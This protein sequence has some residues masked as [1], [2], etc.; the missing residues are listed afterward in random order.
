M[1]KCG[2]AFPELFAKI[3]ARDEIYVSLRDQAGPEFSAATAEQLAIEETALAGDPFAWPHA[4]GRELH[5]EWRAR[6]LKEQGII[7]EI[8]TR[9][10]HFIS[11]VQG[12]L[13][14]S[15]GPI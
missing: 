6:L 7:D 12:L 3:R 14:P 9:G 11:T 4:T 13:V 2:P 8:I 10:G 5:Y 1:R 15:L